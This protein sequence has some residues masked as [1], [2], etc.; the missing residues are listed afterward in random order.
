MRA[1]L[2]GAGQIARQHLNCLKTLPGVQIVGVCDLSPSVAESIAERFGVPA[3]FTDHAAML[4]EVKPDVVHVTTPP[5][6]HFRLAMDALQSGA[7]V[8]V[9]KPATVTFAELEQLLH[10]AGER[11]LMIVED[12]NY[13]FNHAT[14]EIAQ[15][16]DSGK[17]G[18]VVH[19]EVLMTLD[20]FGP[21]GFADPN[22]RHPALALAGGA[23]ADFLPHLASLAHRFIGAHRRAHAIWTKRR[24]SILPYDEFH[25]VV[26]GER[27]TATLGFSATAQPDAFWLRVFGE[28][29]QAS[30]NLFE[31]RLTCERL[32][33]GL[34]PLQPLKNGLEEGKAVRRAAMGTFLR[35]F[36]P[37]PATYDGM[38][39]L[40]AG[41]YQALA[42]G[43]V[44]PVTPEDVLAVNR[45]V[46]ALK[47][48]E[49]AS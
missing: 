10:Y 15:W 27:G 41:T 21:G 36:K 26:E 31:T 14:R 43:T 28:R 37:G 16:V 23:L 30:T 8:L 13:V 17:L 1:A 45:M 22:A 32:R 38:W 44:L 33:D 11:Q 7:H 19:V 24:P 6:S 9:E 49:A 18:A 2:I 48:V 34:K 46:E 3:W 25:G 4:R 47:P 35:K 12:H 40:L 42:Q 5:T 39:H 20:L 29:A